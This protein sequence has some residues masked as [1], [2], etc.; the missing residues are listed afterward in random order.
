MAEQSFAA[1]L[2]ARGNAAR[3]LRLQSKTMTRFPHPRV[4]AV[5]IAVLLGCAALAFAARAANQK[6]R[7]ARAKTARKADPAETLVPFRAGEKLDYRVLWSTFHVNAASVRLAVAERRPF[8]GR[9]AWHF[10]AVAH[11]VEGMRLIFTLDDQFDSYT[12]PRDLASLQYE[13]YLREQGKKQDAIFQMST[14]DDPAPATGAAVRVLPGTRDPLGLLFYL[15]AVDWR[16][17]REVRCPVFDGKKLYQARA[18]LELERDPVS[19]PAGNFAAS[20]IGVRVYERGNQVEQ[21]RFTVWLA[22][23]PSRTPVLIEAEVPLGTARVELTRA[24]Q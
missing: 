10:Q 18:R 15:R 19:V 21:A 17:S 8:Y 6:Q 1:R 7:P 22:Q 23:N 2:V 20:R 5:V 14:E 16:Q 9:E 24:G 11:T 13:M 4:R 3:R 12:E